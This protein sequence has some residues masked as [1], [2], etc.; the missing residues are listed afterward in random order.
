MHDDLSLKPTLPDLLDNSA[1]DSSDGGIR[2]AEPED[3][4]F[5]HSAIERGQ[6]QSFGQESTGQGGKTT[7]RAL[8]GDDDFLQIHS[9]CIQCLRKRAAPVAKPNDGNAALHTG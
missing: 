4:G 7:S 3:I 5:E 9:G 2:N 1:S 6:R 8:A